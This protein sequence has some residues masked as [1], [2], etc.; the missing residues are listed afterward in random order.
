V[1]WLDRI[2]DKKEQEKIPAK[3]R[4]KTTEEIAAELDA[5]DKLKAD[6]AA[7]KLARETDSKKVEEIQTEFE[8][9]KSQLAAAEAN[10]NKQPD[11]KPDNVDP[12]PENMLENPKGVL[13][14]RLGPLEAATIRNG[15]T[16]S[17]MLAQQQLD[18]ADMASGGKD[19]NGRLFRAWG[20]EIDTEARK[21]QA[22]QLMSPEAWIG[23]FWY[24]KG[25]HAD[26]LRDPETRKK[27][28]NFLEP[29]TS[30][31]PA[32]GTNG[33]P[34]KDGPES[35]TDAEKHVADRMGVTYE[36]YAKRKKAM[37]MVNV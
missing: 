36:N 18:N 35:L 1:G 13:D 24:L 6:L 20:S 29:S 15:V 33:E 3:W 9:V 26:E 17:R 28:Y 8:K 19:M 4:D 25:T 10:R 23:I 7:E 2:K 14:T 12:T 22:V 5:S 31:A 21:Y 34:K 37:V 16:T 30:G 32:A 11:K 27:K